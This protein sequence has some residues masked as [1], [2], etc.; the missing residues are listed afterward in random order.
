MHHLRL[1]WYTKVVVAIVLGPQQGRQKEG[2]GNPRVEEAHQSQ[3]GPS[4][5]SFVNE[6]LT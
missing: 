1:G 5:V 3:S 6:C 4:T 2:S